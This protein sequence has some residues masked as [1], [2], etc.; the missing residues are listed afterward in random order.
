[1]MINSYDEWS[2]L[3]E[4]IVGSGLSYDS[5]EIELSF[6]LFFHD[7]A[8]SAFYYPT[9]GGK[10]RKNDESSGAGGRAG[11]R[12]K[13]KQ[14][15][16]DELNEDIEGFVQALEGLSVQVHRPLPLSR[17]I[18]FSTPYW[19]ASC[20]PALNVRDQ[21]IILGDEIIETA[22]QLRAR[23]FENDLLKPIFYEYFGSGAKWTVMP[24]PIMTDR[25]FDT[26]YVSGQ[27]TPAIQEIENCT[28]TEFD[29]GHEMM[30]DGAQCIRLGRDVIVN[31]STRNHGLAA[32]WL[33][34]HSGDRFRF[35]VMHR[36]A[37]NHI[38]SL[39]LPL[40]PGTLLL[41]NPQVAESLPKPLRAWDR[42]YVPE[43]TTN[44]FPQYEVDDLLLTTPYI[45]MNVLSVDE[46]TVVVN[47]LF[48]E[49]I[50][51]LERHGFTVVP[52]RHRHRRLFGGGWHC[53]TLDTV[54]VGGEEDYFG[55]KVWSDAN[56]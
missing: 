52:V 50:T 22:P 7:V 6:R 27:D 17:T 18:D 15:Y 20:V 13:L 43:P 32:R 2:P 51:T 9:Y 1:M 21:V 49:L 48:P 29:I 42:I 39:V 8:H 28:T 46:N 54:R 11:L 10:A 38:D 30:I 3:K 34:R 23:Y 4:V 33:Q 19:Q 24:R 36:F 41:R 45:D 56:Q 31:V 44:I 55:E 37:D 47:S 35:H 25:S 12:R 26:S 53:F 40:R 14:R 16:V 5:H